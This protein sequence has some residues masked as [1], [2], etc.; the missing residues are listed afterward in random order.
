[1]LVGLIT[2]RSEV[3]ILPS[4]PFLR[5]MATKKVFPKLPKELLQIVGVL[6]VVAVLVI[7]SIIFLQDS[8]KTIGVILLFI[9]V[10]AVS[11]LPQ[12]MSPFSFGVEFVSLFT[13]IGAIL[14]GGII[15]ALIGVASMLVSGFYTRESPQDVLIALLGFAGIGYFTPAVYSYC[16]SLG[17]VALTLTI[18]YDFATNLAYRFTGHNLMSC[19]RFSAMHIPSNYFILVYLGP[20][21]F[22]I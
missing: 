22:G 15:G 17:M 12:R 20:R 11:R 4:L 5:L 2:R 1:M 9:G 19:L 13:I 7:Y 10:G 14:Y 16:G 6:T 21:L 3:Q 8:I 18:V